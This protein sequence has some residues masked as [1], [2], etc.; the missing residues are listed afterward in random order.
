MAELPEVSVDER[1]CVGSGDC[2]DVAPTAFAV[3]ED[4]GL[5]RVLPGAAGTDRILLERAAQVP[6]HGH[7]ADPPH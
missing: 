1:R 3:D 6:D 2:V 4:A 5:V 7:R